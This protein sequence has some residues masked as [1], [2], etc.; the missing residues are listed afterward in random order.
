MYDT[1]AKKI[2]ELS[3]EDTKESKLNVSATDWK[4]QCAMAVQYPV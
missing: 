2:L 1:N 4:A 3:V